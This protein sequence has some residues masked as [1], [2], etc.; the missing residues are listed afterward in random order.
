V[1]L[2]L[3]QI[4]VVGLLLGLVRLRANT[5]TSI[6]VHATYNFVLVMVAMHAPELGP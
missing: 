6:A 2:A 3:V 5:T 1:S 4:L